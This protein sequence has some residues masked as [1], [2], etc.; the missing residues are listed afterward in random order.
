MD[1]PL[2]DEA[3]V[4]YPPHIDDEDV[5][6]E[7]IETDFDVGKVGM[8]GLVRMCLGNNAFVREETEHEDGTLEADV[9]LSQ[10]VNTSPSEHH[11]EMS[12]PSFGPVATV[13]AVPADDGTYEFHRPELDTFLD[14]FMSQYL[15]T[16]GRFR[17]GILAAITNE[18]EE[19]RDNTESIDL[20][21]LPDDITVEEAYKRGRETGQHE[22]ADTIYTGIHSRRDRFNAEARLYNWFYESYEEYIAA[23]EGEEEGDGS[24]EDHAVSAEDTT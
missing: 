8:E 14:A 24:D 20:E 19:V 3:S 18:T 21:E 11:N 1:I 17:A 7:V 4:S 9:Y 10:P 15:K 22:M 13:R 6:V 5:P 16:A 12:F 2:P 23:Q